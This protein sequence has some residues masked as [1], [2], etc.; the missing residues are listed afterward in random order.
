MALPDSLDQLRGEPILRWLRESTEGQ[1]DRKGPQAQRRM[2]DEAI[3][4]LGLL[5]TGLEALIENSAWS[6]PDGMKDAPL[7]Q[8]PEFQRI[9]SLAERGAFRVLLVGYTSRFFRDTYNG[10]HYRRW[11][12]E[13]GVVVFICDDE[14]LTSRRADYERF[15]NKLIAAEENSRDKSRLIG[16]A[17]REIWESDGWPGGHPPLGFER[18]HL[19]DN[20]NLPTYWR[21][22]R[23]IADAVA[24]FEKYA[25]GTVN[26]DELAADDP[27]L[28]Q[29][30]RYRGR[31]MTREGIADLIANPI[32]NGWVRRKDEKPKPAPW[33]DNP[34]VSDALWER[35][36]AIRT[37]RAPMAGPAP[38]DRVNLFQGRLYCSSCDARLSLDGMGG[39]NGGR[40]H[41]VR[42]VKPCDGWGKVERHPINWWTDDLETQVTNIDISEEVVADVTRAMNVPD[43]PANISTM[44]F[45]REREKIGK[46]VASLRITG[47]E[48]DA[49][50]QDIKSREDEYRANQKTATP[51]ISA[52][53]VREIL[54][55][56][57]STWAEGSDKAKA[58]IVASIYAKVRVHSDGTFPEDAVT[59]TPYAEAHG[60]WRALPEEVASQ[61][62]G[63]LACPR[64]LEPPTFR[65]AT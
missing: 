42:H 58:K 8:T 62:R 26:F 56:L 2:Q 5:D 53:E 46:D 14:I 35:T 19:E 20:P 21:I 40:Y 24:L 3:L 48:A 6:G 27:P 61:Q 9:L 38:V 30:G 4:R 34:P 63:W 10:L 45:K 7:V 51:T 28:V 1:A 23:R 44:E 39:T 37:A 32:Y 29:H 22:G 12:H 31:P 52:P 47:A 18:L 60:L 65:S 16:S 11:F 25:T 49:R 59:L 43:R 17:F 55:N 64:G 50:L 57:R 13:H 54:T 15:Q 36:Q 33:R 41:R